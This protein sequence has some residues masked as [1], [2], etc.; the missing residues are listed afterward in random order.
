MI[1][2]PPAP[3]KTPR[4]VALLSTLILLALVTVLIVTFFFA[5]GSMRE[6]SSHTISDFR[7]S[8]L[9]DTAINAA[10]EQL[11]EATTQPNQLW[12]SQPGAIRTYSRTTGEPSQIFKLYS[13]DQ[14]RLQD[15][16][17]ILQASTINLETDVPTD[18]HTQPTVY[19]D[20]NEPR[21]FASDGQLHF[22][23]ID[24]RLFDASLSTPEGFSYTIQQPGGSAPIAG[25]IDPNNAPSP[26][27]QRLP[28]PVKWIYVLRDGSRGT[29]NN[30]GKFQPLNPDGTTPTAANPIVSRMAW[31]V[32]DESCKININTASEAIPWDTP[33]AAT[34]ESLDYARHTPVKNEV[35]RFSGHPATTSLS[36]VFFPN[37]IL[38]PTSND[39]RDKLLQIY[40][41][42]PRVNAGDT[43]FLASG[44]NRR[45]P[46]AFDNDRLYATVDELMFA[47]DRSSQPLIQTI[48]SERL[49]RLRPLLTANSSAPETTAA[50]T[51]RISLWPV[52]LNDTDANRTAYDRLLTRAATIGNRPFYFRRND[53]KTSTNEF[54]GAMASNAD[55]EKY[56][57]TLADRKDLGYPKSFIQ[58]YD[59]DVDATSRDVENMAV[60]LVSFLETIRNTNLHDTTIAPN[61]QP[62]VPYANARELFRNT[63][64][65][66]Q[67]PSTNPSNFANSRG[68]LNDHDLRLGPLGREYTLSEFGVVFSY[69]AE[70]KSD[71]TKVNEA[72][73]NALNLP[74][75]FKAIQGAAVFEAFCPSQGYTM[76][77]PGAGI[78]ADFTLITIN[79][80]AP[81]INAATNTSLTRWG[82]YGWNPGSEY[83]DRRWLGGINQTVSNGAVSSAISIPNLYEKSW[84]VGWGG[85]GG[86]FL[87]AGSDTDVGITGSLSP[88]TDPIT[89]APEIPAIYTRGYY[90]V[91]SDQETM[92]LGMSVPQNGTVD[93]SYVEIGIWARRVGIDRFDH[94]KFGHFPTTQIPVP[95]LPANPN[96]LK[97]DGSPTT[98]R[99]RYDRIR[100]NNFANPELIDPNDTVRTLV[101]RSNDYRLAHLRRREHTGPSE[102]RTYTPHPDYFDT[103]KRHAHSFTKSGGEPEPGATFQRGLVNT[104][105]AANIRPDFPVSPSHPSYN[106]QVPDGYPYSIDP[107]IT[108]DWNNGTG[109]APDGAYWN[110]PDDM[111]RRFNGSTPPYFHTLWDGAKDSGNYDNDEE[112]IAPNQQIPSAVIFGG[113]PSAAGDAIPW[114]TYL[115]RPDFGNTHL[116]SANNGINGPLPGAPPDHRIL[117]WFW[118]PVVQPYAISEPFSTAGKINLNYRLAPFGYIKR[119]SGL[120]ALL[121][122]ERLLAIPTNAGTTYKDLSSADSNTGW[123]HRIDAEQTLTQFE[124]R[125]NS[126]RQFRF[127]SEICDLYLIPQ[128][129]TLANVLDFWEDH[130]LSGDNTLERPYANLYPRLTTQ[131]N[132]YTVHVVVQ[133][134]SKARSTPHD[135]F[136]ESQDTITGSYRGEALVERFIDP[137]DPDLPDYIAA[138]QT[139]TSATPLDQFYHWRI[140]HIRRFAP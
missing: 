2:A 96:L 68:Q 42:T 122:S 49:R 48:G 11:R 137:N 26:A 112:T 70:H 43:G 62:V 72:L 100:G 31:W 5:V 99:E 98:W 46:I 17:T 54:A 38:D 139:N 59:G 23:I 47:P 86:R 66:G 28:M 133:T 81:V 29:L 60:G 34:P 7:L 74:P 78:S 12:I 39:G 37:Q 95:T 79:N 27:E 51:P 107:E 30:T 40:S 64:V 53:S 87:F 63:R 18:W 65:P 24:P 101:V 35:Q 1:N 92:T 124:T 130:K 10:I 117:D 138:A 134:I 41:L 69:A 111:A 50:G 75:G 97:S 121:K 110:K 67:I 8:T 61:G 94:C 9:R 83:I 131:S 76:I 123:H 14:P 102:K 118:M 22:P 44:A 56:L 84:W 80:A 114:T 52:F 93:H 116:G 135:E 73:V 6:Q 88:A 15:V 104:P 127:A 126:G 109:L 140:R 16:N 77:S 129:R 91:P 106:T 3:N 89:S 82:P 105:Y 58:K 32:D 57:L 90:I 36:S 125:F 19:V 132:T 13:N 21:L 33:K 120:H 119:A 115:F 85:S 108:R 45:Q 20:L 25:I 55:L 71:G 128:G 136:I 113:I 103:T 4:G